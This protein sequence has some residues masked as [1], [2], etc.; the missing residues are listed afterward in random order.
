MARQEVV[1]KD[2]V[3]KGSKRP[4]GGGSLVMGLHYDKPGLERTKQWK[5]TWKLGMCSGF[6]G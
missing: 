1:S 4:R 3:L 2:G 6:Q 5:L